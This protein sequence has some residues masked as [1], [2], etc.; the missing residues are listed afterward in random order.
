MKV[1]I[2]QW[3]DA[4]VWIEAKWVEN[5]QI[6]YLRN[7]RQM[8]SYHRILLQIITKWP[9]KTQR[10]YER[11]L[12]HYKAKW[13]MQAKT[14]NKLPSMHVTRI[15]ITISSWPKSNANKWTIIAII[16]AVKVRVK[17]TL[18]ITISNMKIIIWAPRRFLSKAQAFSLLTMEMEFIM[19]FGIAL[20]M[21]C[22]IAL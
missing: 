5:I 13:L 22:L 15:T 7:N 16:K 6:H 14:L 3:L 17:M 21:I 1:R 10:S 11:R 2:T 20:S 9:R 12:A 18:F 8:P 4:P 19:S